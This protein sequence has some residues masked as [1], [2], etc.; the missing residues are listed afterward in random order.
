MRTRFLD[1]FTGFVVSVALFSGCTQ[2]TNSTANNDKASFTPTELTQRMQHDRAVEAVIWGMPAVN[3]QLMYAEMAKLGGG[4]N[5]IVYWSGLLDWKNQTL[6]PNPDVIYLMPFINTKDVGPM[7]LE[8]PPADDGVFNG[9]VM[10]YWQSAIEDVG[11]GGVDKGKGGKY[12]ILPP[13]YKGNVPDGYIAMQSDTYANY[14]LLRSVLK[15][16]SDEDV[17]KAIAYG[18]RVKLYPL[19]EAEKNPQTKFVDAKGIVFDSSIR[20][21]ES[22]FESLNTMV[23]AEPWLTRDNAMIDP[24]KTLGIERGKPYNPD[25]KTRQIMIDAMQEAKAWFESQYDT[26]PP[27]YPGERLFFPITEEMHQSVMNGWTTPDSYPID[28]RGSHLARVLQHQ[29]LPRI[30]I[31]PADRPRQGWSTAGRQI[32]LSPSRAGK[33]AGDPVLVDDGL[34]PRDAYVHQERNAHRPLIPEP[35]LAD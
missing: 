14:A 13:G 27:F 33:R 18:I 7:V 28:S 2:T 10:N 32:L 19:S 31:L 1:P 3:Y 8:I 35:G 6:T 29:A 15:S 34:Q 4:Y 24:L 23:Q 17:A 26:L 25:A 5:Q 12:L 9:S 21:D 30:A 11:P 20:Y 22:F 16:G